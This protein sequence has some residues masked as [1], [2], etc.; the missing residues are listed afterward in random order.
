VIHLINLWDALPVP[1]VE[2][3]LVEAA[4]ATP[5]V[6]VKKFEL[7]Q[8]DWH[9]AYAAVSSSV[10]LPWTQ[11]AAHSVVALT[12]ASLGHGTLTQ[13]AWQQISVAAPVRSVSDC[14]H[15][16]LGCQD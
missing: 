1:V 16:H 11:F 2:A 9:E 6:A 5:L 10:P 3:A 4:A 12:W 13:A 7:I 8:L 14:S 15:K